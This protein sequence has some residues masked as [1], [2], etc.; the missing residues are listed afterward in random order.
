M[1]TG[2]SLAAFQK[3][4][5]LPETGELDRITWQRLALH[6]PG[7]ASIAQRKNFPE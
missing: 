4:N 6:Y 1:A 5:D 7:A 2:Q 3:L